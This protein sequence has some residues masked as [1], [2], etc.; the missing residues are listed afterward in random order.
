MWPGLVG[1]G[2][3]SLR[4]LLLHLLLLAEPLQ[5]TGRLSPA[6]LSASAQWERAQ[7]LG[8]DLPLL[9]WMWCFSEPGLMG[10]LEISRSHLMVGPATDQ[11]AI[12]GISF[13]PHLLVLNSF[14]PS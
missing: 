12:Y 7:L 11:P 9:Q 10:L 5:V 14:H 6:G 8:G 13:H 3:C 4:P 1:L 2:L